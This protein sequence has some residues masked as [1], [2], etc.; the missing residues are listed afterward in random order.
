M[1]DK[2]ENAKAQNWVENDRAVGQL[3]L[4]D[5]QGGKLVLVESDRTMHVVDLK[6]PV[7]YLGRLN[8][9]KFSPNV[10]ND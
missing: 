3:V 9:G 6:G 8:Q 2:P 5:S 4:P 7:Y 1:P 10:T